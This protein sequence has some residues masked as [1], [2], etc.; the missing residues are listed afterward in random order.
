[1]GKDG[2]D[3]YQRSE[4]QKMEKRGNETS[5]FGELPGEKD[6]ELAKYIKEETGDGIRRVIKE[7]NG[8]G[9]YCDKTRGE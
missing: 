6:L 7:K 8:M 5:R 3:N 4:I 9:E 2:G 1:M